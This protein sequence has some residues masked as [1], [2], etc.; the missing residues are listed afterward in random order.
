VDPTLAFV[1]YLLALIAFVIGFIWPLFRPTKV[2]TEINVASL[3]LALVTLVW[4][5]QSGHA[6]F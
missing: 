1:L 4:V 6:A 2:F 5:I 3:G